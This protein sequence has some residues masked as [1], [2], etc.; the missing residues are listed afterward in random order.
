MSET[1]GNKRFGPLEPGLSIHDG[2]RVGEE[3]VLYSSAV[4]VP[5]EKEGKQVVFVVGLPGFQPDAGRFDSDGAHVAYDQNEVP[6]AEFEAAGVALV[7]KLKS[8]AAGGLGD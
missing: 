7:E 1:K 8:H 2:W 5:L 4:R 3:F 6:F